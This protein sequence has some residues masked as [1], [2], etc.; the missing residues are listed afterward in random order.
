MK[1]ANYS[2][3]RFL[4][5]ACVTLALTIGSG[6][7]ALNG[8]GCG[9]KRGEKAL[10]DSPENR[11]E[12]AK[13]YLEKVPMKDVLA[14]ASENMANNIPENQRKKFK[15][16]MMQQERI[17]RLENMS[18]ESMAKHFTTEE[19]HALMQFYS[20]KHGKSVMQKFGLY[21]SDIMPA[22]QQEMMRVVASMVE[23]EPPT[24]Q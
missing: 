3:T 18:V 13:M 22:I 7:D 20:N 6:C 10:P 23:P 2:W 1:V 9:A 16:V 15:K 8:L 17:D 24:A 21:M 19:I 5:A 11:V 12:A 4:F 14:E